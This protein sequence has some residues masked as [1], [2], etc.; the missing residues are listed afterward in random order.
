[1]LKKTKIYRVKTYLCLFVSCY[2]FLIVLDNLFIL[3]ILFFHFFGLLDVLY[4]A[5]QQ[6]PGVLQFIKGF[7]QMW[8]IATSQAPQP[9][10]C[11]TS[12]VL[13]VM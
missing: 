1:M 3:F 5:T 12:L 9:I 6:L 8:T 10:R 13:W 7:N 11:L 4:A 2:K